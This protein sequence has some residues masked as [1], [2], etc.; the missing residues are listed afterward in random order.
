MEQKETRRYTHVL[1]FGKDP[2]QWQ[3]W[4][5]MVK[6]GLQS[7][8]MG[9][10]FS[11]FA[12]LDYNEVIQHIEERQ[13]LEIVYISDDI[14][15]KEQAAQ[16]IAIAL[17]EHKYRPWVVIDSGLNYLKPIFESARIKVLQCPLEIAI[18]ERWDNQIA[19]PATA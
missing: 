14:K 9:W 10:T 1:V 5:L 6:G 8:H 4:R 15:L 7:M 12:A 11:S 13:D 2:D 3:H 19:E 18:H 17:G 16:L